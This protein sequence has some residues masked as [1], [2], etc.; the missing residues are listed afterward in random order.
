[1]IIT[2]D[3]NV[4]ELRELLQMLLSPHKGFNGAVFIGKRG[5]EI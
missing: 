5:C 3:E 4:I 2:G 1:M